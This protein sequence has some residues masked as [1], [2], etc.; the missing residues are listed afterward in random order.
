MIIWSL[1]AFIAIARSE[2]RGW[3][4]GSVKLH[5]GLQ[6]VISLILVLSTVIAVEWKAFTSRDVIQVG[7]TFWLLAGLYREGW[8]WVWLRLREALRSGGVST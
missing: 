5:P 7:Y 3:L 1:A 8:P 6:F 2:G 4:L